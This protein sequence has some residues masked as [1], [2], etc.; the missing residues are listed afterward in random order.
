MQ[1]TPSN[2]ASL[3][4]FLF[5]L[6]LLWRENCPK[7]CILN[8]LAEW[9]FDSHTL[10]TGLAF[11]DVNEVWECRVPGYNNDSINKRSPIQSY[12]W[13]PPEAWHCSQRTLS[14]DDILRHFCWVATLIEPNFPWQGYSGTSLCVWIYS[15]SFHASRSCNVDVLR[16]GTFCYFFWAVHDCE[17][18][19]KDIRQ[20][21]RFCLVAQMKLPLFVIEGLVAKLATREEESLHNEPYTET[22]LSLFTGL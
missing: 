12:N 16:L 13:K 14:L 2:R 11:L 9:I 21:H 22:L 10:G 19:L 5:I 1:L 7:L 20:L 15:P 8:V 3:K 18:Y 17:N 4:F 6:G